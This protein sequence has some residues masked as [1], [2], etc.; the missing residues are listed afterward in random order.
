MI[1]E[2]GVTTRKKTIAITIGETKLPKKIPIL[3]QIL[4]NG[5]KIFEFINPRIRNIK[6]I[7]RLQTLISPL[8]NKGK[9]ETIKKKI[10]KTIPKLL[11]EP[12]LILFLL[13]I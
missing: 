12:I 4:F 8:L 3:N 2:V 6:P 1:K 7:T 13:I 5:V 10:K 11:L 9:I